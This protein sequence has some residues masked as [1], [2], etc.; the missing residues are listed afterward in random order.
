GWACPQTIFME[1]VFRKI[2]YLIDGDASAQRKLEKAPWTS[3]KI[4]KRVLKHTIFLAISFFIANI[5]LSY[6]ISMDEL[7]KIISEPISMHLTGLIAIVIFSLVFYFVFSWMREQVC[8]A[9]CPYGRLQGVMLDQNSIVVA[10]DFIRGEPRGKKKKKKVPDAVESSPLGDCIDCKLC[11]Q[12]CPT[13]IDIRNGTQLEC[14][15]CT[16][17][18]DACDTVMEKI[19]RPKGLIRYDSRKGIE[20]GH[21]KVF[22]PRVKAYSTVLVVLL[23]AIGV[24]FSFRTN[25][26]AIVTQVRGTNYQE[27]G[28][29]KISNFFM[30]DVVNKIG[31]TVP[32][33]M[34]IKDGLGTIEFIGSKFDSIYEPNS[35]G[36]ISVTVDKKNLKGRQTNLVLEI[37]SDGKVLTRENINFV[38]P[39]R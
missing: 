37:V 22:T 30:Y 25:V 14:V 17:C 29:N 21:Q 13:G 28:D 31:H 6:I 24:M 16:A 27:V 20:E 7:K 18:I 39:F 8:I 5:F 3:Q 10:Y 4:F 34:R 19:D 1:M 15:N 36:R 38:G 9:V 23:I 26:E 2:E 32:G 35:T 11:V 12:V 33:E